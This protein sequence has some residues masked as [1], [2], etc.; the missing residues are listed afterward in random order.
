MIGP[1]QTYSLWDTTDNIK[2]PPC[3]PLIYMGTLLLYTSAPVQTFS[4]GTPPGGK[5]PVDLRLNGLL[6]CN[7]AFNNK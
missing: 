5:Q 2:T 7:A 4:P 3:T 1:V 6:G